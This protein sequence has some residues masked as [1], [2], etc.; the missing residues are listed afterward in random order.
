MFDGAV[1][2]NRNGIPDAM[3]DNNKNGVPDSV[4][5]NLDSIL[6]HPDAK[7]AD[8]VYV[9]Y[10]VE[11]DGNDSNLNGVPDHLEDRN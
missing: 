5:H 8:T 9:M 2:K 10:P 3:E 7:N 4:E 6:N 11:V 1:D